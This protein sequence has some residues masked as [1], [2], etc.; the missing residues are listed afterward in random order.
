MK[1]ALLFL[2]AIGFVTVPL[3]TAQ[4]AHAQTGGN[5]T[6]ANETV[7][8]LR[9]KLQNRSQRIDE[10]EQ[11]KS[12]L[13]TKVVSLNS[14]IQKLEFRNE[15]AKK[16]TGFTTREAQELKSMG[17]WNPYDDEPAFLIFVASENGGLYQYVGP[18]N[19]EHSFNGMG[20]WTRVLGG[21]V[22]LLGNVTVTLK[23][24]PDGVAMEHVFSSTTALS[25]IRQLVDK[26]NKP[27]TRHA[28]EQWN[29]EKRQSAETTERSTIGLT[30]VGVLGLMFL[31]AWV[32][33]KNHILNRRRRQ[34]KESVTKSSLDGKSQ[35]R[36]WN[37]VLRIPILKRIGVW[38]IKRRMMQ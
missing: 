20:A 25:K 28:W 1:R 35:S 12:D 18:G 10:L 14:Q 33:S 26:V 16:N 7:Q 27:G 38:W 36:F 2:I 4:T 6:A 13:Q 32:E 21:D 15:Q 23:Y 19:G 30:S 9:E 8:N 24:S 5:T 29:N 37:L 3:A 11:Q 31:A 34:R 17:A 22:T